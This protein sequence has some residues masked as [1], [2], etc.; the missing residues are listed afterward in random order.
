MVKEQLD[1]AIE[2]RN[3]KKAKPRL[4][5]GR[6]CF[7]CGGLGSGRDVHRHREL[8]V[9]LD[10]KCRKQVETFRTGGSITERR[11]FVRFFGPLRY[12]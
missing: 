12:L 5:N 7:I 11:Q 1:N 8:G 3:G 10:G 4:G 9:D 6:T 2:L